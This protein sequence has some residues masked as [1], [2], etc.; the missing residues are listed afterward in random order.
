MILWLKN[1]E[2]QCNGLWGYW[3]PGKLSVNL[4]RAHEVEVIMSST[5]HI[6]KSFIY[7]FLQSFLKTGLL[8]SNGQK[9]IERRRIL[10][11]AFHFNILQQF[12]KIF[13]EHSDLLVDEFEQEIGNKNGIHLQETFSRFTLNTISGELIQLLSIIYILLSMFIQNICIFFIR[14]CYGNTSR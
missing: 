8:T 1:K 6:N 10:T 13:L 12:Q 4:I 9:W 3:V 2:K 14:D 11:P 5:K 7:E